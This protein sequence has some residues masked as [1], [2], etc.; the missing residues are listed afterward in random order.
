MPI[1][2]GERRIFGPRPEAEHGQSFPL[3]SAGCSP[4]CCSIGYESSPILDVCSQAVGRG[5]GWHSGVA[6]VAAP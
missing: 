2:E 4:S 6:E 5:Q 3:S 1:D